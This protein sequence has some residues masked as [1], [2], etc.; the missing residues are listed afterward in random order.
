[1]EEHP[2]DNRATTSKIPQDLRDICPLNNTNDDGKL[3]VGN[4]L[5]R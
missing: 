2:L 4:G 1:V 3:Y 5:S